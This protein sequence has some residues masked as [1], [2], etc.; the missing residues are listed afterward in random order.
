M[1]SDYLNQSTILLQKEALDRN[2]AIKKACEPL[3]EKGYI[4]SDYVNN[5]IDAIEKLGPYM[6]I[7]PGVALIHARPC[8]A[9]KRNCMSL[10]TLK[11]PVKFGNE[12]ND[13]VKIIFSLATTENEGHLEVL[14]ELSNLI[15]KKS[16]IDMLAECSDVN[17]LVGY[18]N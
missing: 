14:G 16:F 12:D 4:L 10:M 7:I 6:V 9:V 11:T 17:Q 18:F 15:S 1:L 13:P 8:E 5:I 3:C 2:D